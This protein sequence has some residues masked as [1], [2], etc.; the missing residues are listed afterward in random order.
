VAFLQL[1]G[2]VSAFALTFV[3]A[4][5]TK[6]ANAPG[7]QSPER[8]SEAEYDVAKEYFSKDQPRAALDHSRKAIELWD[9]NTKALYLAAVIHLYFCSG[10]EGLSAPDCNLAEAE[11]YARQAVKL[12]DGFRDAKNALGNILVLE[13]KYSEAITVVEPLTRDPA[14]TASHLAWGNLGWAQTMNGA[15]DAGIASLKNAIAAQPKFCVG[16]FRLGMA[17]EK[18]QDFAQAEASLTNAIASDSPDCQRLQDAWE[19]RGRVRM[20]L[21]KTA[22]A[23]ADYEKCKELASEAKTGKACIAMLGAGPPQ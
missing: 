3:L 13:K 23:R 5:G 10:N 17:Y 11:K 14:Y 6:G 19:A 7:A 9:E 22:E 1:H 18:K 21:G 2:F 16:H 8:Q 12:D 20:R 4:C 15:V